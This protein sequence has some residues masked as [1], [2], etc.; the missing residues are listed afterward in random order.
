M[1]NMKFEGVYAVLVTPFK[2]D[3]SIDEEKLRAHVD[4]VIEGGVSGVI[5]GGSTAEFACLSQ[6]ERKTIIKL[7]IDHVKTLPNT[8][9]F[10]TSVLQANGG[11]QIFYEKLK[12]LF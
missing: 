12:K 10:E 6:E 9:K 11:P 3:E 7:V 5:T 2:E 4:R 1:T 8:T